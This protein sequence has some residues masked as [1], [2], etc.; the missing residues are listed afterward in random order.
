MLPWNPPSSFSLGA[1]NPPD[2]PRYSTP[3]SSSDSPNHPLHHHPPQQQQQQQQQQQPQQQQQ[4][5]QYPPMTLASTLHFLQSEHR[6]YARDRNEWEIERAEM[7]ARIAL[8]EGEKRGNEGALKSLARRCR[9][10][11]MALRGERSKFLSS[12][13]SATGGATGGAGAGAGGLASTSSASVSGTSSPLPLPLGTLPPSAFVGASGPGTPALGGGPGGAG[14]A[15]GAGGPTATAA[16]IKLDKVA[17]LKG[18]SSGGIPITGSPTKPEDKEGSL[19]PT[20]T[21]KEGDGP[22]QPEPEPVVEGGGE[23]APLNDVARASA[24]MEPSSSSTGV[25]SSTTTT[26]TTSSSTSSVTSTAAAAPPSLNLPTGQSVPNGVTSVAGGGGQ[27]QAQTGTGTWGLTMGATLGGRDPRGKARSREYLKQCLQ[28]ITYLTSSSTL[29]PLSV[30][31]YAAPH[32]ARP[33]KVLPDWVPPPSTSNPPTTGAGNPNAPSGAGGGQGQAQGSK[34]TLAGGGESK[35]AKEVANGRVPGMINLAGLVGAPKP[36]APSAPPPPPSSFSSAPTSTTDSTT[37]NRE[38]GSTAQPPPPAAAAAASSLEDSLA[39][40]SSSANTTTSGGDAG[41]SA[42]QSSTTTSST[43]SSTNV[44]ASLLTAFPSDPPSSFVPLKRTISR[45]GQGSI[46]SI[47]VDDDVDGNGRSTNEDALIEER[48]AMDKGEEKQRQVE[49]EDD[50]APINAKEGV[51]ARPEQE[52]VRKGEDSSDPIP[53]LSTLN[54]D[55]GLASASTETSTPR[56]QAE[57]VKRNGSSEEKEDEKSEVVGATT[58]DEVEAVEQSQEERREDRMNP[59][60]EETENAK[61]GARQVEEGRGEEGK[62]REQ[63][64]AQDRKEEVTAIFRP[65]SETDWK[66]RLRDAGLRAYPSVSHNSSRIGR[67]GFARNGHEQSRDE[68]LDRLE[69]DMEEPESDGDEGATRRNG[70]GKTK[71]GAKEADSNL[72][73][74]LSRFKFGSKAVLRSHLEAVRVVRVVEGGRDTTDEVVVS[75][76]DDFVVKVWRGAFGDGKRPPRSDLE[77]ILTLR[78]H[79]LPLTSLCHSPLHSLL[80]SSSLDS[81]V[82]IHRLPFDLASHGTYDPADPSFHVGSIE[83]ASNAIWGVVLL[84]NGGKED[85]VALIAA[86]GTVQVWDWKERDVIRKWTW[87]WTEEEK[88]FSLGRTGRKKLPHPPSPTAI[89]VVQGSEGKEQIAVVWGNAIVKV[90]HAGTGEFVRRLAA[91]QTSDGTPDTQ[92]NALA[93]NSTDRFLATAHEDRYI[94]LFDLSSQSPEPILST[95]AHLDGVTSIAFAPTTNEDGDI[96]LVSVSHDTSI[97]VW[98]V[99]G[100][101][102]VES[103][104]S[105]PS[106]PPTMTCVQEISAHRTKSAEGILDVAFR[107]D[108]QGF[109]TAGADGTVRVWSR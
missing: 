18:E 43:S 45:P 46:R 99:E 33:R 5:Q 57:E 3:S 2:P 11:E 19:A 41:A 91:D 31:S 10:L 77:P 55:P 24:A 37:T 34:E 105:T 109:V 97:R 12:T 54:L 47:N 8:L 101:S 68:E 7:R 64:K 6:R 20:A 39:P 69:W 81:T 14:F 78:G 70:T 4:Q 25:T 102:T 71:V 23:G 73:A 63:R 22:A 58:V 17:Q 89:H 56:N 32:V 59:S 49:E 29:N 79:T 90:Y 72:V 40:S 51:E 61:D 92:I 44:P 65:E 9:M 42:S 96:V 94:R 107:P 28:E 52:E 84:E 82:Q 66:E 85:R 26:T 86:D 53:S 60:T 98:S 48:Q 35:D 21:S 93:V 36:P 88:Q 76:G 38:P 30:T 75:A 103:E 100:L 87:E 50:K 13:T 106:P 80:F 108:G 74:G 62:G 27:G 83:P 1:N 16:A 95:L 67:S 104:A 15:A